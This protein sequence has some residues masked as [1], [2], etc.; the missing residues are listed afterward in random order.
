MASPF[1]IFFGPIEIG[2]TRYPRPL[3]VVE[4][5][6]ARHP[7]TILFISTKI[8]T[9]YNVNDD[10]LIEPDDPDFPA[11]GLKERSFISCRRLYDLPTNSAP[12]GALAG[13]LLKRFKKHYGPKAA[14]PETAKVWFF[15]STTSWPAQW[16]SSRARRPS[17]GRT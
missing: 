14:S 12:I 8:D 1:Q 10:F 2:Q 16:N 3:L 6:T 15:M 11:T 17:F 9:F 4:E 7:A 5:S 13:D